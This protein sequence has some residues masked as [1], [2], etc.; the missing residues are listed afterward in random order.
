MPSTE[1]KTVNAGPQ[2]DLSDVEATISKTSPDPESG[3]WM[4][5]TMQT[6]KCAVKQ[7]QFYVTLVV[8]IVLE[9]IVIA[10][11]SNPLYHVLFCY[12]FFLTSTAPIATTGFTFF[13]GEI[14]SDSKTNKSFL[15]LASST[16]IS[17]IFAKS[18]QNAS[19]LGAKYGVAGGFAYAAWYV[20]FVSCAAVIYKLRMLGYK[21]LP[22][23]IQS[24]YGSA[25]MIF[26]AF[27]ILYRLYNEVWSNSLVV[28]SFF[29]SESHSSEY[30]WSNILSTAIPLVYVL[31]GGLK[32]SLYSDVLQAV[33]F[34]LGLVVVLISVG[35]QH[36][37]NDVLKGY[38]EENHTSSSFMNYNPAGTSDDR[39]PLT[40]A[41]GMDLLI[42]GALQGA[43]SY[44]F[45]DPVLTDR[46]FLAN[47]KT[48]AR[49]LTAGGL[50]AGAFIVLFSFIG[51]YGSMLGQCVEA[52]VCPESDLNGASLSSVK[53]GVPAEVAKTISEGIFNLLFLVMAT[54]SISTLDST[55]TSTAKLCAPELFGFWETGAPVPLSEATDLHV[56]VGRFSMVAMA[57]IGTLPLLMNVTELSATTISG[58][59]VMGLAGPVV[60]LA[61]FPWKKGEV[62][63]LAFLAPFLTGAAIGVAYMVRYSLKNAD[64]TLKY[65]DLNVDFTPLTIGEGSYGMLL[66]VNVLGACLSV[67]LWFLFA[68][69]DWCFGNYEDEGEKKEEAASEDVEKGN[70]EWISR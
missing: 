64:G 62:K 22:A 12:F 24:N 8:F 10:T 37:E 59:V 13:K 54:S 43:L 21:S 42:T 39:N 52:G 7:P 68:T 55:F 29:T 32:S 11:D 25:S 15:V 30:W 14:E 6:L 51:V 70:K 65:P 33:M 31:M 69:S 5:D 44:P 53:G 47:P 36:S 3:S 46:A 40:L 27:A 38:L 57:I 48:N 19:V 20:S 66:G 56:K 60:L 61:F 58:T 63:P 49:A 9:I 35:V 34:I 26:F 2:A 67:F 23:A 4:D 16:M 50:V 28:S 45:F 18:V 1:L 41:G 17:W